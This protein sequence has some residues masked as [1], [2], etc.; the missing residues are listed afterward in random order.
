[1]NK[2][3]REDK[4]FKTSLAV[5]RHGG[6]AIVGSFL[7]NMI[8]FLTQVLLVRLLGPE[9]Y[10]L[11]T[12][13]FSIFT[14][15]GQISQLG[16]SEGIIKF[17]SVY[18]TEKDQPRL[19]GLFKLASILTVIVAAL[20]AIFIFISA[21]HIAKNIFDKEELEFVL[22]FFAVSIPFYV[23]AA[24]LTASARA[25]QSIF[26]YSLM[27]YILHPAI[28]IICL[29]VSC[30]VGLTIIHALKS[31]V[32]AW[33]LVA[34]FGAI[35][36]FKISRV[37][38]FKGKP[39]YEPQKLFRFAMPVYIARFLP[40]VINQFDKVILGKMVLAGDIG[41]YAAGGKIAAQIVIFMQAFNLIVAPVIAEH[42]HNN[43][44]KELN[45]LFKTV[46]RW[47]I[48][49][50]L[51]FVLFIIIYAELIMGMFGVEYV[52]GKNILILC[53][54][55]QFVNVCTGP[56]EYMLIMGKQDLDLI[57]NCAFVLINII[58]NYLF[59][60]NYGI[61]GAA[62]AL[63]LSMMIINLVRLLEMYILYR[64]WPYSANVL[65]SF[66][67]AF[68]TYGLVIMLNKFFPN[69]SW[70]IMSLLLLGSYAGLLCFMGFNHEEREILVLIKRKVGGIFV[71]RD[72]P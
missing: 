22:K 58:L 44:L 33:V 16:L 55:A 57:N 47:T 72:N 29:V 59:I 24:I 39:I 31:F 48:S 51:P 34:V 42:F 66:L 6:I 53:C 28:Y 54:L 15:A 18:S 41:V 50:T 14:I 45:S 13:G 27:Q 20:T 21:S 70:P 61:L 37:L 4:T 46:T 35:A 12:I 40:L 63:G 10:G 19:K 11:Y 3:T 9:K 32:L 8:R 1:M 71:S 7:G 65:K 67:A 36:I 17:G 69:L 56:L 30:L 25:T 2:N 26:Y 23:F 49:L 38:L 68:I 62:L 64:L 5:A 43:K 52:V 60:K